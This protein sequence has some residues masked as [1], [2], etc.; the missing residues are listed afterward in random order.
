MLKPKA[1]LSSA[2]PLFEMVPCVLYVL[3]S[4]IVMLLGVPTSWE[5]LPGL[6]TEGWS[7]DPNPAQPE[8]TLLPCVELEAFVGLRFL[9]LSGGLCPSAR[10]GSQISLLLQQLWASS[11]N[12]RAVITPPGCALPSLLSQGPGGMWPCP[13]F[14]KQP[15]DTTLDSG[16]PTLLTHL[17]A[18]FWRYLCLGHC[19]KQKYRFLGLVPRAVHVNKP[20]WGLPC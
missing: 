14:A 18:T 17:Q 9:V 10:T 12:S 11:L 20:P 1:S 8:S 4:F 3:T 15:P 6:H 5:T 16:F 2:C 19:S 7:Q 13:I